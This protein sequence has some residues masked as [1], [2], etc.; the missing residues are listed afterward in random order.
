MS[1]V[2]DILALP[3]CYRLLI[4]LG[5]NRL[6]RVYAREYVKASPGDRILDLGCG[7][8]DFVEHVPGTFYCG[9]DS[10]V[11]YIRYAQKKYSGEARFFCR[12]VDGVLDEEF[13][14][15]DIVLANGVLHHLNDEQAARLI[16]LADTA[17]K[18]E[19]RFVTF[20]PCLTENQSALSGWLTRHDRGGFVRTNEGY[21]RLAS[22]VFPRVESEVRTDIDL[23]SV[24][25]TIMVCFR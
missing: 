14:D 12:N 20:D 2:R 6:R 19:G 8:G 13:S 21:R 24:P 15:F 9:L 16:R 17:L 25:F 5:V 11:R 1:G 18:S 23:F 7:L 22:A 4:N 3:F 10:N